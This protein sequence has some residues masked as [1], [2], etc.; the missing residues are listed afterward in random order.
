MGFLDNSGDII[1]DAV[2]T[3]EGRKR[4]AAGDGSFNIVKFALGDDEIDYSLFNKNHTSGSAYYDLEILQTPILEAMTNANSSLKSPLITHLNNNKLYLPVLRINTKLSSTATAATT[5]SFH[6]AVTKTSRDAFSSLDGTL[7]GFAPRAGESFIR[8]DQ[9]L[10]TLF[11]IP[12]DSPLDAEDRETQY[13]VYMDN[14]LGELTNLNGR[15]V[16]K[17]FVDDDNIA[18]YYVT[19][20]ANPNIVTLNTETEQAAATEII[21]GPRG[22]TL[23]FKIK[24]TLNLR[25]SNYLF[26]N[27]GST[28][29]LIDKDSTSTAIRFI[30]STV[31]VM[32]ATTGYRVDIPIRF[33]KTSA[34]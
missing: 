9:G 13:I 32:G 19:L 5:G 22:T 26:T 20:R 4:L 16:R 18:T 23:Q 27:I 8:V 7:D 11:Q 2:L 29:T 21:E 6:I 3:D 15:V 28:G 17:S 12:A 14:R 33:V 10:D 30:D 31:Q 1:L 25:R 34:E 24:S